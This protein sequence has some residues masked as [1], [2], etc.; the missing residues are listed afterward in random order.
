MNL[1]Q[2]LLINEDYI[3]NLIKSADISNPENRPHQNENELPD[4]L[5]NI[6]PE[7]DK[8]SD[9]GM[10][11]PEGNPDG[12]P[13]I[14]APP[15]ESN[16]RFTNLE[17]ILITLIGNEEDFTKSAGIDDEIFYRSYDFPTEPFVPGSPKETRKDHPFS[18]KSGLFT[19][20]Q[21]YASGDITIQSLL[22]LYMK[23]KEM[24]DKEVEDLVVFIQRQEPSFTK[25][26]IDFLIKEVENLYSD[27][28]E[29]GNFTESYNPDDE[30]LP[31]T[32]DYSL[33]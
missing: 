15:E 10:D 18:S 7:E 31:P 13:P 12:K 23:L 8:S 17:K 24:S 25:E 2:H 6:E 16:M 4:S 21:E 9:E 1:K 14:G 26:N 3:E 32:K 28:L 20:L 27:I 5:P 33:G 29:A 11:L 19:L 22:Y 30:D